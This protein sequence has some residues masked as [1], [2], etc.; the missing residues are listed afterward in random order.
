MK[1]RRPREHILET[2]SVRKFESLLPPEWTSGRV[3]D[4]YGVDL[5][6][7]VFEKSGT[8]ASNTGLEFGVQLKATDSETARGTKVAVDW[9][10]IEY[11]HSLSYPVLVVRYLAA[12]DQA[13]GIWV[14][15]RGER[16]EEA[17][18]K[19]AWF[20]FEPRHELGEWEKVSSDIAAFRATRER[21]VRLPITF[22]FAGPVASRELSARLN[23]QISSRIGPG[24][25]SLLFENASNSR[26]ITFSETQ[27]TLSLGGGSAT[28]I[29]DLER[30][31]TTPTPLH[32]EDMASST[33][34]CTHS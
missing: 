19:Q 24:V 20:H 29:H 17:D 16:R 15:D 34:G 21:S 23:G 4:D 6:I 14:H 28:H 8:G 10:H 22:A 3:A 9:G 12:T 2:L 11:W 7:E 13:F 25:V 27:L 31:T 5:R 33:G 32:A 30:R 26:R 18:L 1:Q